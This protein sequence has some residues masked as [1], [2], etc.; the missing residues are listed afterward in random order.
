[1]TVAKSHPVLL[2]GLTDVIS[3]VRLKHPYFQTLLVFLT[4]PAV[5]GEWKHKQIIKT[6]GGKD[7]VKEICDQQVWCLEKRDDECVYGKV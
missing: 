5:F 6:S 2:Q 1:M 7:A 4:P 3:K